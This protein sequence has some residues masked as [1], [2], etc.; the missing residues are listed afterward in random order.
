MEAFSGPFGDAVGAL[1]F[2]AAAE[3][4]AQHKGHVAEVYRIAI[5]HYEKGAATLR[6]ILGSHIELIVIPRLR[7]RMKFINAI[8][9]GAPMVGLLGTVFGMMGAFS[10][11]AGAEGA[12]VDPKDL[13]G[14]IGVALATTFMGL[15]VAIPV[16]FAST[17]LRARVDQFEIDLERYSD[18]CIDL[19][20]TAAPMASQEAAAALTSIA[21]NTDAA[22]PAEIP[23]T[24]APAPA[25]PPPSFPAEPVRRD[26]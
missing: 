22:A 23:A 26:D 12:G 14:N 17:Y 2:D 3:I 11:I 24:P 5:Q 13:A 8:G 20:Y 18:H 19:L 9:R 10:T 4:C 1:R 25:P 7:A 21:G 6:I 15:L 16:V